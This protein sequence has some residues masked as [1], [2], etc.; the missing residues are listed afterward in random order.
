MASRCYN[1]NLAREGNNTLTFVHVHTLSETACLAVC[2]RVA[3]TVRTP[4]QKIHTAPGGMC[5]HTLSYLMTF[6]ASMSA[7]K[8]GI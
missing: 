8:I 2:A 7:S 5:S 3:F 6:Y 4:K 1:G